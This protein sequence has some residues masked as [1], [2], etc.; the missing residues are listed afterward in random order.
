MEKLCP[1][2]NEL[3]GWLTMFLL[4]PS[5]YGENGTISLASLKSL[6]HNIGLDRVRTVRSSTATITTTATIPTATI[7]TATTMHTTSGSC[8]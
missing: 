2:T 6:L 1:L 7:P 5:S 8:G 3:I 4:T